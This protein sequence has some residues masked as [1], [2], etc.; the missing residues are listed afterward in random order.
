MA[1]GSEVTCAE[2]GRLVESNDDLI[3]GV[4]GLGPKIYAYHTDCYGKMLK[5]VAFLRFSILN[6]NYSKFV[7]VLMLGVG[8]IGLIISASSESVWPWFWRIFFLF[9]V[10]WTWLRYLSWNRYERKLP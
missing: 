8:F 10:Y 1:S 9:S 7:I 5:G 4:W 2:C 6:N 3:V